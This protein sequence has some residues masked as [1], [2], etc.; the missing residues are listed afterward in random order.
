MCPIL[1]LTTR[2]RGWDDNIR[3]T[4][5]LLVVLP[6]RI[7]QALDTSMYRIMYSMQKIKTRI[8][9]STHFSLYHCWGILETGKASLNT[10]VCVSSS[11]VRQCASSSS[12][13][14][15]RL[16]ARLD[17]GKVKLKQRHIHQDVGHH[18]VVVHRCRRLTHL[19]ST[20]I[21]VYCDLDVNL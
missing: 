18:G 17:L 1:S 13:L 16:G 6:F 9:L 12:F 11:S 8:N 10:C 19:I 2:R 15:Y 3:N 20:E 5:L 4:W 7:D 14:H 21:D